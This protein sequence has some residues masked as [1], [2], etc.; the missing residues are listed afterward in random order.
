MSADG[1][2]SQA[3]P[4]LVVGSVALDTI[5]T[6]QR[7]G[8]EVLGGS[9][10][11]VSLVSSVFAPVRL[12]AVVGEDF[13][14]RHHQVLACRGVDLAG[15]SIEPGKTFH[16]EGRYDDDLVGRRTICTELNVFETF[17]PVIPGAFR[18]TPIVFLANIDPDL[19]ASVLDQM[20]SPEWV[21]LDTMNFWMTGPKRDSLSKLL[22]RVHAVLINDEEARL[23]TGLYNLPA[24]ARWV[25]QRGPEVVVIKRGDCGALA[26]IRDGWFWVPPYLEG[27][28]VDPTGAG[29]SF[30]AGFLGS[31]A[32]WG[33]DDTGLRRSLLIGAAA[34]SCAIEKFGAEALVEMNL[35]E[36]L[37]RARRIRDIGSAPGP[38]PALDE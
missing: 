9:A 14:E 38:D 31:L 19:Q 22:S 13:S 32:R 37:F 26:R 24:A 4:I 11:Y 7:Q 8:V 3:K 10:S 23:L 36:I 5:S 21:V 30:A 29:D 2:T 33:L 15:L 20:E 17:R 28:V 12:V 18:A 16:W 1:L 6:P 34:A 25:Q 27:G 35:N